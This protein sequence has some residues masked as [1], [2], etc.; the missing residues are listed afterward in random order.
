V[1][2]FLDSYETRVTGRE[3]FVR[4]FFLLIALLLL[5]AGIDW[6]LAKLGRSNLSDFR[7]QWQV[8]AFFGDL[9][10]QR[11]EEAYRRWGCD[12]SQPCRDYR[13]EKFLEDWGPKARYG[14]PQKVQVE[15]TRHCDGGIIRTVNFG[16][17]DSTVHLYISKTDRT[18]SFSPWP[19]CNP[20]IPVP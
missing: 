5:V 6:I 4:L 2:E 18:I 12:K 8:R 1:P 7:E 9:Q 14:D 16:Q 13:F 11:Y 15:V 10:S 20:R 3:K 19:V 17:P